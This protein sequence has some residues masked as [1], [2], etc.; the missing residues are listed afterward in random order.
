MWK[1]AASACLRA[2]RKGGSRGACGDHPEPVRRA[3]MQSTIRGV[4]ASPGIVV[5][6]A[7]LLKWEVPEVRHRIISDEE[8]DDELERFDQ[9]LRDAADRLRQVRE[10]AER[11][12]GPEE[13]AIFDVQLTILEDVEL[14]DAVRSYVRQNL[15]AEKAFDL[16]MLEWRQ[17]FA[18]HALPMVR[19]RVG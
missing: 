14:R 18:R 19:E 2:G 6:P 5:G 11:R 16:V 12:A 13:A 15:G 17:N 10:R 3:L 9:S 8:I 1:H 7:H 4:P